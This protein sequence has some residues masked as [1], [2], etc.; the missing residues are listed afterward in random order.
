MP[1][2]MTDL[3]AEAR[4]LRAELARCGTELNHAQALERVAHAHGARDWNT[5]AARI[6]AVT[7]PRRN[8]PATPVMV[9]QTVSGRYMGQGLTARVHA[10]ATLPGGMWKVTLQLDEPVDVVSFDSFSAY[11]S[12][13]TATVR[14]DGVSPAHRSDGTP[15]LVL[16]L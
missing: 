11:R 14:N 6:A 2:T 1:D 3:K 13:V 12:R 15:H 8:I 5:L 10:L 9:G 7:A 16:D 4:A